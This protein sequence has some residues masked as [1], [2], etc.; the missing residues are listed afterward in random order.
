MN[1]E[2]PINLN[3][4]GTPITCERLQDKIPF[5]GITSDKNLDPIQ[6]PYPT[7][8]YMISFKGDDPEP[9]QM[10]RSRTFDQMLEFPGSN[11]IEYDLTGKRQFLRAIK[12]EDDRYI[13]DYLDI[14][15]TY[16]VYTHKIYIVKFTTIGSVFHGDLKISQYDFDTEYV[17]GWTTCEFDTIK[18]FNMDHYPIIYFS[19]KMPG[20][21]MFGSIPDHD[22][23]PDPKPQVSR[24]PHRPR[25]P[26][27]KDY[28]LTTRN[29]P[30]P[31]KRY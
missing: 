20:Y 27:T 25:Q 10:P 14:H 29:H 7:V 5:N 26:R 23:D 19:W 16:W 11:T 22:P 1:Q 18:S 4:V 30:K 28:R 6:L 12:N 15:P 24:H 21:Q 9:V 8:T 2:T 13:I 17:N 3:E 31:P